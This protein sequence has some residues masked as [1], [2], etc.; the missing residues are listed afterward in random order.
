[1]NLKWQKAHDYD[2]LGRCDRWKLADMNALSAPNR[3]WVQKVRQTN[4]YEAMV[5]RPASGG[6]GWEHIGHFDTLEEAKAVTIAEVRM[7]R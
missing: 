6:F 2:S 7:E 4:T 3:A 5:W 1:M